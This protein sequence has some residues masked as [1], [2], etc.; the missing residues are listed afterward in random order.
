MGHESPLIARIR[1]ILKGSNPAAGE[2]A[3]IK[4]KESNGN[5]KDELIIEFET[6]EI[7]GSEVDFRLLQIYE[8]LLEDILVEKV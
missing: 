5:K 4:D 1:E 8:F 3:A 6:N 7:S 2:Y